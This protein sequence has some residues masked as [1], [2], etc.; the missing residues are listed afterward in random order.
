MFP[1][2]VLA[3]HYVTH[4]TIRLILAR[5][6]TFTFDAGQ[7]VNIQF[8]NKQQKPYTIASSPHDAVLEFIIKIY[9][10]HQGVSLLFASLH[11]GDTLTISAPFGIFTYNGQDALFIAAG[12]GITPFLS[13][14]RTYKGNH[15][16]LFSNKEHK[17]IIFEQ[18]LRILAS[19]SVFFLSREQREGYVYGRIDAAAIT[20]YYKQHAIYVCGPPA[21]SAMARKI[22]KQIQSMDMI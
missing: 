10:D 20:Q 16:L 1:T 18:E 8:A 12:V 21:F 2:T 9:K 7:S 13:M 4:D 14:L 6:A 22:S 19:T 5:P 15:T 17:D 11:I 3:K